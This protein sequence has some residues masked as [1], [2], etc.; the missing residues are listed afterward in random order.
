M[1]NDLE[2]H[3]WMYNHKKE[4]QQLKI[5]KQNEQLLISKMLKIVSKSISAT[6]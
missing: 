2:I 3:L 6:N 5:Y 1:K 4:S